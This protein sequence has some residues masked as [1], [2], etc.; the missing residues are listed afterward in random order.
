MTGRIPTAFRQHVADFTDSHNVPLQ[1]RYDGE[2]MQR[3]LIW[4]NVL[5]S[6]SQPSSAQQLASAFQA[7]IK[8]I[9]KF[10]SQT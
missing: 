8:D 4:N 2:D 6:K 3:L 10:K 7:K 9:L 1:P 5:Y